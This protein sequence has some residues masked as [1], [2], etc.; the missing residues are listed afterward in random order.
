MCTLPQCRCRHCNRSST[1]LLPTV[2]SFPSKGMNCTAIPFELT[3]FRLTGLLLDFAQNGA[4]NVPG[5]FDPWILPLPVSVILCLKFCRV[6]SFLSVSVFSRIQSILLSLLC[7]STVI[8]CCRK[9]GVFYRMRN[10]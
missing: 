5:I 4:K 2:S 8:K 9:R 10:E 3:S 7:R 1:L 6:V